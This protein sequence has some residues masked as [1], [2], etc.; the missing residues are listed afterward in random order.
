MIRHAHGKD[1]S[2]LAALHARC[3]DRPWSAH[4]FKDLLKL[5]TTLALVAEDHSVD[6]LSLVA[7]LSDE[8]EILTL[9]VNPDRRR[10]GLARQLLQEAFANLKAAGT[11]RLFLEVSE[12]N[13][14]AIALY[15]SFGFAVSG[16]RPNYYLEGT[17]RADAILMTRLLSSS[18]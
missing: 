3:F 18:L 16:R 1:A 7:R 12:H 6:A 5:K 10:T 15:A 2:E 13:S 17:Q 4:A 8:A 14:A 9:A 11:R